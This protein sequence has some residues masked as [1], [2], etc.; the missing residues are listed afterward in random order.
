MMLSIKSDANFNTMITAIKE[1]LPPDNTMPIDYYHHRKAMNG[2]G[3]L[4]L[5]L[6]KVVAFCIR[7]MML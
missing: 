5:M 6:A 4:K 1:V 7:S 2:F 3:L